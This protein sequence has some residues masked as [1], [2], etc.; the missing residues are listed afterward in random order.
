MN[1]QAETRFLW[2]VIT[3]IRNADTGRIDLLSRP[4][5]EIKGYEPFQSEYRADHKFILSDSESS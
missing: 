2:P 1:A 5:I 3:Q 4:V